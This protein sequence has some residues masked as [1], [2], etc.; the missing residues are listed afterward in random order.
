M[1]LM[2]MIIGT[3]KT[4]SMKKTSRTSTRDNSKS[5]FGKMIRATVGRQKKVWPMSL[6]IINKM[7][8]VSFQQMQNLMIDSIKCMMM[9]MKVLMKM[10]M[11]HSSV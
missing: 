4:S 2:K 3:I 7:Q 6:M 8:V 1:I 10:M 5:G 11:F 9:V